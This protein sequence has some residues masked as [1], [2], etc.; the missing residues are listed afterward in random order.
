MSYVIYLWE[1]P[2]GQPL[3]ANIA[4]AVAQVDGQRDHNTGPNPKFAALAARLSEGYPGRKKGADGEPERMPWRGERIDGQT[5]RAVL[6]LGLTTR[7]LDK[8]RPFAIK[9][10]TA[11]GL[12]V[13]DEQ[14]GEVFLPNGRFLSVHVEPGEDG[15]AAYNRNDYAQAMVVLRPLAE[16][17]NQ[18]A[19]VYVAMMYRDGL[20]VTE[21]FAE[22][23]RW[24]ALAAAAGSANARNGLGLLYRD[25][26]GVEKD[27]KEAVR[28]FRAAAKDG[29]AR[30]QF[31]LGLL[32]QRGDGVR[33]D[34]AKAQAW[35]REAAARGLVGA[36]VALGEMYGFGDGVAKDPAE[37]IKWYRLAAEQGNA[38][39]ARNLGLMLRDG[40]GAPAD[41]VE[42]CK[43]FRVA[44]EKG[45]AAG[46]NL[47]GRALLAGEGCTKDV[48]EGVRWMRLAADQGNIS[49]QYGLASAYQDGTGVPASM[50]VAFAL[51]QLVKR[52]EPTVYAGINPTRLAPGQ[53]V[54]QVIDAG[55]ELLEEIAKPGNLLQAIDA[56]LAVVA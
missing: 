9:V 12:C 41:P 50:V 27:L 20:G 28:L 36:Q 5:V 30:A 47:L 19:Q 39:A 6:N 43:W 40:E 22:A 4:E 45:L 44:A 21:D 32:C 29:Y 52:K 17:G 54:E 10:A 56:Y 53:T 42:A 49:A 25:G 26:K 18:R 2:A 11:L 31:N 23:A 55:S 24:Y 1:P 15:V 35:Y 34:I 33:K 48:D 46:Q 3:P 51:R 8:E 37:A 16:Q 7:S 13:M 14:A 38:S